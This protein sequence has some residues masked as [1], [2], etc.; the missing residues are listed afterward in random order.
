MKDI[1]TQMKGQLSRWE[2]K[3]LFNLYNEACAEKSGVAYEA[4]KTAENVYF[5][6]VIC[7]TSKEEINRIEKII[8]FSEDVAPSN[9]EDFNLANFVM[10]TKGN[11]LTYEDIKVNG[12][13]EAIALAATGDGVKTLQVIYDIG[14]LN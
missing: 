4:I 7:I 5:M 12:T 6:I 8:D 9:W 1:Y 11:G 3:P 13:R 14:K 2:E 10:Q